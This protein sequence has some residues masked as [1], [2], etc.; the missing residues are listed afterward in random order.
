MDGSRKAAKQQQQTSKKSTTT[1]NNDDADDDYMSDKI[2]SHMYLTV[3]KLV[4]ILLFKK[5]FYFFITAKIRGQVC[6]FRV[7]QLESTSWKKSSRL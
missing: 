4:K 3:I 7:Q 1:N 2:L 5:I 6:C